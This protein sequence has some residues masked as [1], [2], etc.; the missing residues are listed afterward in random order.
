MCYFMASNS[1]THPKGSQFDLGLENVKG[2]P[3]LMGLISVITR[4][5]PIHSCWTLDVLLKQQEFRAH[6]IST[7]SDNGRED[8]IV[9]PKHFQILSCLS[10][11]GCGQGTCKFWC[12][13][14]NG[15]WTAKP[16]CVSTGPIKGCWVLCYAHGICFRA[17]GQKH[18]HE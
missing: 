4:E 13:V 18:A 12:T 9:H 11:V 2:C 6:D 14:V 8:F 15:N 17:F 7:I 16:W 10:H 5:L 3:W 1:L